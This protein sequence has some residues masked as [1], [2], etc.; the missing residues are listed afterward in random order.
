MLALVVGSL[1]EGALAWSLAGSRAELDGKEATAARRERMNTAKEADLRAQ[2]AKLLD[3]ANLVARKE[4]AVAAGLVGVQVERIEG[5]LERQQNADR[6]WPKEA[7]EPAKDGPGAMKSAGER[8]L[9][10]LERRYEL[11][12]RSKP[13]ASAEIEARTAALAD[14][15]AACAERIGRGSIDSYRL[16]AE[17]EVDL[18]VLRDLARV[19]GISAD[20]I[21]TN[22]FELLDTETLPRI[23]QLQIRKVAAVKERDA[24]FSGLYTVA[25]QNEEGTLAQ[26]KDAKGK[27]GVDLVSLFSEA[28]DSKPISSE[29]ASVL[30]KASQ[31]SVRTAAIELR[32]GQLIAKAAAI[33]YENVGLRLRLRHLEQRVDVKGPGGPRESATQR[34]V[35]E[36]ARASSPKEPAA[37]RDSL[38]AAAARPEDVA[39]FVLKFN[40]VRFADPVRAAELLVVLK[41]S[42]EADTGKAVGSGNSREFKQWMA[43]HLTPGQWYEIETVWLRPTLDI[44]S[45]LA[46]LNLPDASNPAD[47]IDVRETISAFSQEFEGRPKDLKG[48]EARL[49]AALSPERVSDHEL[50]N[51]L[52]ILAE[53]APRSAEAKT[54]LREKAV[55]GLAAQQ[56]KLETFLEDAEVEIKKADGIA[57]DVRMSDQELSSL[58]EVKSVRESVKESYQAI[59]R[60]L[61]TILEE[62]PGNARAQQIK[63]RVEQKLAAMP[64]PP[65][66]EVAAAADWEDPTIARR[67]KDAKAM[68]AEVDLAK[69]SFEVVKLSY[70]FHGD[71]LPHEYD[72][73]GK[74][75]EALANMPKEQ[76]V[77]KFTEVF[78][79]IY[80][81]DKILKVRDS[82]RAAK[83]GS[84]D[85]QSGSEFSRYVK[86]DSV[87]FL[88]R[89][90]LD[91]EFF[92]IDGHVRV[93]HKVGDK[94]FNCPVYIAD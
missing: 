48:G 86:G 28:I 82:L 15:A 81:G 29:A 18:N 60:R 74:V 23:E 83:D 84:L 44:L 61:Q 38:K 14:L 50:Y 9:Q 79:G 76:R 21:P 6:S 68:L 87:E 75:A 24:L 11:I 92:R 64:P 13:T 10:E 65:E 51:E 93:M 47:L 5:A 27:R 56:Y 20:S 17:I 88:G 69:A 42:F 35:L 36:H 46:A 39:A 77:M 41:K 54:A 78:R 89:D 52:R 32:E 7:A 30:E 43:G 57:A 26:I 94:V 59:A 91:R 66:T 45:D 73:S 1:I 22:V 8:T 49:H 33:D 12:E 72:G 40:E 3:R 25:V 90:E 63:L 80:P 16:Q 31:E 67:I 55:E 53:R 4:R 19:L 58:E 70:E 62:E 85:R 2:D 71:R 34:A 37:L